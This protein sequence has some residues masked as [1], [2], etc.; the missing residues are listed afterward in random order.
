MG[1][2][3]FCKGSEKFSD[4]AKPGGALDLKYQNT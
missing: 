3:T 4:M 2:R 1:L